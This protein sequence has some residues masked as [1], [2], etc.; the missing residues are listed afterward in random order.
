MDGDGVSVGPGAGVVC[1]GDGER[2]RE[3]TGVRSVSSANL[4]VEAAGLGFVVDESDSM[5]RM[6][7]RRRFGGDTAGSV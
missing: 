2:T 3:D 5:I 7:I 6:G 4:L 1:E